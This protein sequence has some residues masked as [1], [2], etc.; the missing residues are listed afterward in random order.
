MFSFEKTRAMIES[1]PSEERAR[2]AQYFQYQVTVEAPKWWAAV[3]REMTT[4][5]E[6]ADFLMHGFATVGLHSYNETFYAIKNMG[7]R[8]E[9]EVKDRFTVKPRNVERDS[10]IVRLHEQEGLTFGQIPRRLQSLNPKWAR[11]GGR[12]MERDAVEKAYHRM[13]KRAADE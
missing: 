9:S 11:E 4:P 1:L 12:P 7:K 13:K 5:Q 6:L 10:A 2:M 3:L 8:I